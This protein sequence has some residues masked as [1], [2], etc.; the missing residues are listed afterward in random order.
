MPELEFAVQGARPVPYCA[1]P[2]LGLS[3][4]VRNAEGDSVHA[5]SLD[6]QVRIDAQRRRYSPSEKEKLVELFGDPQRWSQT[7]RSLLWTHAGVN[8][9]P[10]QTEVEVEL[11]VPCTADF[12]VLAGKFFSAL[13]PGGTVPISLL[14]SGSIFYAGEDGGLQMTRIPWSAEATF[15]LEVRAWKDVVEMYYPNIAWLTLRQDT[16]DSLYAYK[17]RRGLPT[18]EQALEELLAIAAEE[19]RR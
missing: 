17:T 7:L 12:N 13:E 4:R 8:V 6:C 11:H 1:T 14:F 16:F 18:W 15:E 5:V 2:T 9:P 19:A 3:L 10:F